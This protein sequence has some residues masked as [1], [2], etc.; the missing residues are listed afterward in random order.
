METANPTLIPV[1]EAARLAGVSRVHIY[2]LINRGVVRA[3][4]VGDERGPLRVDREAFLAWL[5]A[6]PT[7]PEEN[8]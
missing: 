4:R 1:R 3:V 7:P 5:Y 8:Q 6:E 2:R